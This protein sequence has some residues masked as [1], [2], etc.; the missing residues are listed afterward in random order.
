MSPRS[1]KVLV[2]VALLA[3]L[4]LVHVERGRSVRPSPWHDEMLRAAATSAA[5]ARHLKRQ[6]LERGVFVDP[7][8]DPTESALIGQEY[9]QITTDRGYLEAKLASLD[10]NFAAVVVDMAH[11]IGLRA[12]DCV[13]VAVTGSFP[14]LN[15]STL[16]ALET[17]GA[18][19]ALISS[20]G[21]SNYGATDP[22]FTWLDMEREV[23]SR[24]ILATRSLAASLG[25]GLDA[26]RGL[27]PR[28]RELLRTAIR[29]NGVDL[30]SAPRLED[31][32]RERMALYARACAPQ[33]VA[34]YVNVGGG[35]ASLG[36]SLNSG[37]IESG[38]SLRLPRRNFPARGALLR[39]AEEDVPIIH[40]AGVR[41]LRD[42]Y[43][44]AGEFDAV[45]APGRGAVY[46]EVRYSLL[47]TSLLTALLA[48]TLFAL[49]AHDRRV[50]R[51]G[52]AE[53]DA[54]PP[55]PAT[56]AKATVASL[57]ALLLLAAAPA[58]RAQ[59]TVRQWVSLTPLE[60]PELVELVS[61][62][63]LVDYW[64]N[65]PGEPF[66]LEVI[67]PTDLRIFTRVECTPEMRGRIHYRLQVRNEA[68][69]INT[70]QLSS[71]RSEV[72]SYR[73]LDTLVPGRAAEIVIPVPAG[74]HRYQ[75][76]PMD[77]DKSTLLARFMLPRE[78]LALTA[79]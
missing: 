24:G 35:V 4:A 15:L 55:A 12:G 60:S 79:E 45:P 76:V 3:L 41:R 65:R 25:G 43:G 54:A 64:R 10:P 75:I 62:E 52:G 8:N 28:G 42:R 20:V 22:Y 68:S 71:R 74:R 38:A 13:A 6:R 72:T 51:L 37:L 11:E 30:L 17:L 56:T 59:Q 46:G 5:A 39:F 1:L 63:N 23:A 50:H 78:D 40:L 16:A 69:V 48:A 26:G 61:R 73:A 18:R 29:R 7:V 66:S 14:A 57:F 19:P 21:A 49:F 67:G 31:A 58:A 32:I 2:P 47:R 70:F 34:A 27:S 53:P 44:L 9:T 77:P 33:P 36:H